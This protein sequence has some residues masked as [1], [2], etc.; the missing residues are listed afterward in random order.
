LVS[1]ASSTTVKGD[2]WRATAVNGLV[3]VGAAGSGT[4]ANG[5]SWRVAG[6]FGKLSKIP[7]VVLILNS[8]WSWKY[9]SSVLRVTAG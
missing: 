1:A 2:S 8:D 5:E 9:G 7:R 3:A 6:W 4:T